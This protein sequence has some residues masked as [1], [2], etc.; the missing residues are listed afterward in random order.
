MPYL[1][2]LSKSRRKSATLAKFS[3][4]QEIDRICNEIKVLPDE[5]I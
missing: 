2:A 4:I 1:R 3:M 5:I